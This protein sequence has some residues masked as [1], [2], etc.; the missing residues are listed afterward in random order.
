MK[1]MVKGLLLDVKTRTLKDVE[2]E[3]DY[4]EI[5]KLLGSDHMGVIYLPIGEG[6][7]VA[8]YYDDEGKINNKWDKVK[9]ISV[10][11][12]R[13]DKPQDY[14]LGNVLMVNAETDD[15]GYCVSLSEGNK[16]RLELN[17]DINTILGGTGYILA[18]YTNY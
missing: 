7:F 15:E 5:N 17:F 11:M 6:R 1:K 3:D 18:D 10:W 2:F 14:V 9:D 4:K 12:F 13:N 8:C 16:R